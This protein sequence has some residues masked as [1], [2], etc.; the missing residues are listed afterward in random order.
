MKKV[1]YFLFSFILFMIFGLNANASANISVSKNSIVEGES[2]VVKL[3]SYASTWNLHVESTGPV[4]K[5]S[6]KQAD[7]T[8]DLSS[9]SKSWSVTCKSTGPGTIV[10]TLLGDTTDDEGHTKDVSVTKKVVVSKKVV[11]TTTLKSTTTTTSKTTK[12]TTTT[13]SEEKNTTTVATTTTTSI[14]PLT[15]T[16]IAETGFTERFY[17]EKKEFIRNI[18]IVGYNIDFS[19]NKKEYTINVSKDVEELYII[20]DSEYNYTNTNIVNIKNIKSFEIASS[21]T[22]EKIKINITRNSNEELLIIIIAIVSF[23]FL[24]LLIEYI[25]KIREIKALK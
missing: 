25:F 23:L 18:K 22:G 17:D 11:T 10:I 24:A 4:D 12:K 16:I 15:T 3:T 20:I 8:D 1:K 14:E 19:P 5:C 13:K 7:G 2:F 6:I 9:V 21:E